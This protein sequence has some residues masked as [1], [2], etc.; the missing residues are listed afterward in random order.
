MARVDNDAVDLEIKVDLNWYQLGFQLA[1]KDSQNQ[2][3]FLVAFQQALSEWSSYS[4][5]AQFEMI[6][7]EFKKHNED[8]RVNLANYLE[9]LAAR[10]KDG[11]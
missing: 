6:A 5:L 7:E 3:M 9:E 1:D 10:L 2:Y 8:D 4:R 11:N